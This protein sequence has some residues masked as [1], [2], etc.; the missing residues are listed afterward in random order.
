MAK[1]GEKMYLVRFWYA[2]A[3][4]I[5]PVTFKKEQEAEK[6]KIIKVNFGQPIKTNGAVTLNKLL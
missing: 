1:T 3:N 5:F 6:T 4:K 2:F